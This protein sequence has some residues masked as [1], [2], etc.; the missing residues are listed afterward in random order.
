MPSNIY[1][2]AG[3]MA[4]L[5]IMRRFLVILWVAVGIGLAGLAYFPL[6]PSIMADPQL[7]AEYHFYA[8][9]LTNTLPTVFH[10][11]ISWR[12]LLLIPVFMGLFVSKKTWR[13]EMAFLACILIIPFLLAWFK[14][15]HHYERTFLVLIPAFCLLVALCLDTMK[16]PSKLRTWAFPTI[17]LYCTVTMILS[18]LVYAEILK[19]DIIKGSPRKVSL[20]CNYW[21]AHYHPNATL[22]DFKSIRSNS[23]KFVKWRY[24]Q[25]ALLLYLR[26]Y[27]KERIIENDDS[28]YVISSEYVP[29]EYTGFTIE[30]INKVIDFHNI[31]LVRR[32]GAS[33]MI[34]ITL[35]FNKILGSP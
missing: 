30:R 19:N 24:D 18:T 16:W 27:F 31:Y 2:I 5:V 9:S 32:T 35:W 22:R 28:L 33:P 25:A 29:G 1:A 10:S 17:A 6:I 26:K 3:I 12:Y 21:Q 34:N 13:R 14:G 7:K 8:D 15:G 11:F 23:V 4:G 20:L